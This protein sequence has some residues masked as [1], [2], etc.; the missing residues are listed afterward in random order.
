MVR[1]LPVVLRAG[2]KGTIIAHSASVKSLAYLPPARSC[3]RRVRSVQAINISVQL[4]NRTESQPTGFIQL[5]LNQALSIYALGGMALSQV[6]FI[7]SV[8]RIGIAMASMHIN[9][10]SFYVMLIMLMLGASWNW[11]QAL[12]AAIVGVGVI[13]AQRR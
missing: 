3:R 10:A 12:G 2:S 11:M 5:V 8:G 7:A 13:V 9:T 4:S 6:L 1:G